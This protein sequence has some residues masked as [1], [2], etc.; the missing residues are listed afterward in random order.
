M[1]C[2]A[3]LDVRNYQSL[4]RKEMDIFFTMETKKSHSRIDYE[5]VQICTILIFQDCSGW[6]KLPISPESSINQT[7]PLEQK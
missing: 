1:C 7:V 5:I 6:S 2:R 3:S 4:L